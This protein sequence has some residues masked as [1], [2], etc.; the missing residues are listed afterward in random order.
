MATAQINR[1]LTTI[2]TE[3]EFLVD[4]EV[5]DTALSD[6]IIASLPKRYTAGD[7][8][9][10]VDKLRLALLAS[11]RSAS[12]DGIPPEKAACVAQ[13]A[14]V[15]T[16]TSSAIESGPPSYPAPPAPKQKQKFYKV[17][18]YYK[19]L[20]D[21]Q[22]REATDISL[23]AG[24]KLAVIEYLSPDWWKG[25]KLGQTPEE[26]GIFPANY[27]TQS[28]KSEFKANTSKKKKPQKNTPPLGEAYQAPMQPPMQP[29][30]Q[31]NLQ[32][33][34]YGGYNQYPPAQYQAPPAQYP[35]PMQYQN[36][37][38][39]QKPQ[40]PSGGLFTDN[41][42]HITDLSNKLGETV[43]YGGGYTIGSN[44]ANRIFPAKP[45]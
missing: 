4:S 39:P 23:A 20:Y 29:P 11:G 16:T 42:P 34:L 38:K 14:V 33:P 5:I 28:M 40:K 27:V 9:Y 15:E 13:I 18:G 45:Y 32:N 17:L 3:L 24:D 44:L 41:H 31:S 26:A 25:Y 19:S 6:A 2:R 1:S 30:M 8:K 22:A 10:G 12:N 36:P 21:F 35:P 7:L 37:Q 43:I